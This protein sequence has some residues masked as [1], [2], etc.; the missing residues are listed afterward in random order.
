MKD[1]MYYQ[2]ADRKT[3]GQC[4]SADQDTVVMIFVM[5]IIDHVKQNMIS[6]EA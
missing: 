3:G 1:Q 4:I 2:H 6:L 5:T